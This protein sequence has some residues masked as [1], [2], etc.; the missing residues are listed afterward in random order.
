MNL[1]DEYLMAYADGYLSDAEMARIAALIV[2]DDVLANRVAAHRDLRQAVRAAFDPA[3]EELPPQRLIDAVEGARVSALPAW[4]VLA[5]T[6][7]VGVIAGVGAVSLGNRALTGGENGLEARGALRVELDRGLAS[8]PAP[9]RAR[10]GLSYRT[11]EGYCRTFTVA[12]APAWD[13]VACRAGNSWV[14]EMAVRAMTAA[15]GARYRPAASSL[16]PA[17]LRTVE[18]AI[19]GEPLDATQEAAAKAAYW[20]G[21]R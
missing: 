5:A 20:R 7:F 16:P 11:K 3:L 1:T 14:I 15:D 9:R 21:D 19:Q 18:T 8:D 17:I 10:V 4:S 12:A 2:D 6:L 13:G